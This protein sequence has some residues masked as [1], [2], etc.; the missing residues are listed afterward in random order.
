MKKIKWKIQPKETGRFA[1]FHKRG[2]PMAWY[3]PPRG[4][5]DDH[6]KPAISIHCDDSYSKRVADS[7]EHQPLHVYIAD[8]REKNWQW[9]K[10]KNSYSNLDDAKA[11]GM[12]VLDAHPE[13]QP[14][15]F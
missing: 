5:P 3:V 6:E 8:H 11:A 15:E 2:W 12:A 10:L 13:F 1:S 14:K 7:S 9:R 4:T